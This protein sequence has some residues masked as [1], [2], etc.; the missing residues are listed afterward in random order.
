MVVE[1]GLLAK[2]ALHTNDREYD[3]RTPFHEM[4]LPSHF[5]PRGSIGGY[6]ESRMR[7]AGPSA[8]F[9]LEARRIE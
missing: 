5:A 4:G 3:R 1:T 7:E 9:W 8:T 6:L 2:T